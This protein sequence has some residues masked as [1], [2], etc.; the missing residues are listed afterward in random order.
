MAVNLKQNADASAG[1]QGT[2]GDDG[3]F[4][5]LTSPYNATANASILTLGDSVMNRRMVVK[6]ISGLPNV[7]TTNA[8]TITVYKAASGTAIASG[9]AL[10]SGTFNCQGT[11]NTNQTLTLSTTS[12]VVDVAAGTRIGAVISGVPGAAGAG[13]ITVTLAPA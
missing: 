1:L 4:I 10:H 3:G 6:A 2:D 12:G 11:A 9:T 13:S 7:A 8:V 5:V